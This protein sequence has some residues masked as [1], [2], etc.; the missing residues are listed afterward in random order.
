MEVI[1]AID[2]MRMKDDLLKKLLI[3]ISISIISLC[4]LMLYTFQLQ[5]EENIDALLG[6]ASNEI[7]E[8][9][10]KSNRYYIACTAIESG[11]NDLCGNLGEEVDRYHCN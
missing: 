2:N 3:I 9:L 6:S 7:S 10:L 1:L 11:N 4:F 5:G 8:I